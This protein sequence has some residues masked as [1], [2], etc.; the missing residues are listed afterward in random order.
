M[1]IWTQTKFID[2]GRP[3]AAVLAVSACLLSGA[4]WAQNA[5]R[6]VGKSVDKPASQ[7]AKQNAGRYTMTPTPNGFLRLDT[8]TGAVSLCT[9]KNDAVTCRSG[10]DERAA[11]DAEISRLAK[12]NTELEEKLKTAS[13]TPSQRLKE[14][15]PSD[16]EMDKALTYAEKLMRRIMKMMREEQKQPDRI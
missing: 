14:I 5:A 10:A 7:A 2:I 12:R 13:K 3:L 1:A 11:L 9:V 15:L 6:P 8:S 4:V 16:K